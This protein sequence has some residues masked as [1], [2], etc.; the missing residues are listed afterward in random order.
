VV[1]W[2]LYWLLADRIFPP[3]LVNILGGRPD[4]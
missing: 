1:M 2:F 4:D 3:G